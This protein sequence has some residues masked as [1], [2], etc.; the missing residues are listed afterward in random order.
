MEAPEQMNQPGQ[1]APRAAAPIGS[2]HVCQKAKARATVL[3]AVSPS[4]QTHQYTLEMRS[5]GHRNRQLS[6]YDNKR[7]VTLKYGTRIH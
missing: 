2:E 4:W 5:A 6:G 7:V 3:L 1:S